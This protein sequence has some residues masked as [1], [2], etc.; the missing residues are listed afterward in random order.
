[1]V[2]RMWGWLDTCMFT[3]Y[4]FPMIKTFRH[5]G[6]EGYF[7]R[8]SKAGIQASHERRLRLQ[9]T[10]LDGARNQED[11]NAPG[12]KLHPLKGKLQDAWAVWVDGNYRLIFRFEGEDVYDVDYRDYH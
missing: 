5:K 2:A 7:L 12:W 11:M 6:I 8:G 1:M 3:V 9:L 10:R 4:D